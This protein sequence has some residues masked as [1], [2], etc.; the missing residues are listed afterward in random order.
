M[1][2]VSAPIKKN[3]IRP[4]YHFALFDASFRLLEWSSGLGGYL[5]MEFTEKIDLWRI[6]PELIGNEKT[7]HAIVHHRRKELVI[8]SVGKTQKNGPIRYNLLLRAG[9]E[10]ESDFKGILCV[11]EDLMSQWVPTEC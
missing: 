10:K 4:I 2:S 7:V 8:T 1:V 9:P 11:L 3:E 5:G 6:F